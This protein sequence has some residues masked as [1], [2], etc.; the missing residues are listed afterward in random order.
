MRYLLYS[1]LFFLPF[2][3][4]AAKYES[5]LGYSVELPYGYVF[6]GAELLEPDVVVTGSSDPMLL[7]VINQLKQSK[8]AR[9]HDYIFWLGTFRRDFKEHVRVA[10]MREMAPKGL[11]EAE[12]FCKN[13]AVILKQL[14]SN[15]P[16][17]HQC[18]HV[19]VGG[20]SGLFSEYDSSVPNAKVLTLH[21][22]GDNNQ[23][24]E[25]SATVLKVNL[26]ARRQQFLDIV[27]QVEVR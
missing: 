20:K 5:A 8:Q 21:L 15:A 22:N 18:M 10:R 23:S 9:F 25:F 12:A 2:N 11:L 24:L 19:S 13:F 17:L 4:L 3:V 1:F 16:E 27:R 6:V 26:E 14:Y 7:T